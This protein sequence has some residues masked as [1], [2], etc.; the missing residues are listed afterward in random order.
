MG[1]TLLFPSFYHALPKRVLV[2]CILCMLYT[3][4]LIHLLWLKRATLKITFWPAQLLLWIHL[5]FH[6]ARIFLDN[7]V[8][9]PLKGAIGGSSFSVY[10]ILESILFVIGLTFTIL[11]MVNERTQIAHK[12]ASLHDPLTNV[13]N[14]RALLNEAEN[15][16]SRCLRQ[17]N[18]LQ[19]CCSISI[20]LKAST[21][22][23]AIIR[24]IGC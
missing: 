13:W 12:H 23:L 19:R 11:A 8:V 24:G 3:S 7:A 17:Q 4:A 6:L 16:I 18:P 10:V 1:T 21:I 14:R 2:L 15:I 9:S 20:I 22:A 5:L